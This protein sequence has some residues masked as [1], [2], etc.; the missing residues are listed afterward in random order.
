MIFPYP[1]E[2]GLFPYVICGYNPGEPT[3]CIEAVNGEHAYERARAAGI[4][5]ARKPMI[6]CESWARRCTFTDDK[7]EVPSD[8][9]IPIEIYLD[10][11]RTIYFIRED[12]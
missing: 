4:K 8:V 11:G 9:H 3:I 5:G 10:D 6:D 2:P 1:T 12:H 7:S